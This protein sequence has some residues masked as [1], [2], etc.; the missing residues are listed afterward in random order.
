MQ[1]PEDFG[2]NEDTGADEALRL[3]MERERRARAFYVRC[4]SVVNDPGV[5]K[6]FDFLAREEGHHFELLEREHDRFIAGEY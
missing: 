4:A 5:R 2:V 1:E 3:A 6:M